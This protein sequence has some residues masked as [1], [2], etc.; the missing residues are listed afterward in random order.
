MRLIGTDA[1]AWSVICLSRCH[2]REPHK[3]GWNRSICRLGYGLGWSKEPRVRWGPR[4]RHVKGQ[5]WGRKGTGPGH[6]RRSIYSKWLSRGSNGTVRM[7]SRAYILHQV[8]IG[9]ALRMLLNRLCG[10]DSTM[11]NY[12]DHFLHSLKLRCESIKKLECGPMP[13]V[14]AAQLNIGGALCESS[15]VLFLVPYRKVWLTPAAGVQ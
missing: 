8:H 11:S 1:V 15:V 6:V 5:F 4:S 14:M 7:P 12:F 10:G 2:D 13:N 9:A 3:N